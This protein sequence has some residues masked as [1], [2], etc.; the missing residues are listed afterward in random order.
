MANFYVIDG[1]PVIQSEACCEIV[2]ARKHKKKRINKK[3]AKRYGS[4][5]VP[6][7]GIIVANGRIIVHPKTFDKLRQQ[8]IE[9]ENG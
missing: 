9:N 6:Y 4:R 8:L 3:W 1:Y 7:N 2:Q 5:F